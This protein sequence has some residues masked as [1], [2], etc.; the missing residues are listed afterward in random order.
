MSFLNIQ[1]KDGAS[2]AINPVMLSFLRTTAE[3]WLFLFRGPDSVFQSARYSDTLRCLWLLLCFS[4]SKAVPKNGWNWKGPPEIAC[5]NSPFVCVL[6][7]AI[8]QT[9]YICSTLL[10]SINNLTIF[11][12]LFINQ[13]LVES[14]AKNPVFSLMW[15][16]ALRIWPQGWVQST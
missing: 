10:T 14:V 12:K 6:L 9:T 15:S 1:Q 16:R 2:V 8:M 5:S 4:S 7:T 11:H 3:D 13:F